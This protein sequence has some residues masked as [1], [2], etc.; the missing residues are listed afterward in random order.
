[1]TTDSVGIMAI[2]YGDTAVSFIDL[3]S[4]LGARFSF[5]SVGEDSLMVAP[6]LIIN[7]KEIT[8]DKSRM[9][10]SAPAAGS[11]SATRWASA[12]DTAGVIYCI[13]F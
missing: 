6:R 4:G 11:T 10:Q 3:D 1:M 12:V 13:A 5:M 2:A 9:E 8:I 7:Q